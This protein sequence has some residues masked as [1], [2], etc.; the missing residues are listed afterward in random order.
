MERVELH[1]HLLPGVDD[2]PPDLAT[3]LE[4][5]RAAVRDGTR[6]GHLHAACGVRGHRRDSRA[7]A[8][9][10]GRA[11]EAASSSRSAP[12]PSSRGRRAR[13]STPPSSR[14]PPR[15]RP[16]GAG[17]CSKR[18]CRAPARSPTCRTAA[19]ELRDRGYGLL[20]GHP[21]RSPALVGAPGAVERLL[22][23]GDRL[24]V[25]GSS[26]TGY[27][28]AAARAAG[29]E[30]VN[31]GRATAIASDAHRPDERAPSLSAAVAVLRRHGTPDPQAEA[32]VLGRAAGAARA[33]AAGPRP[34]GGLTLSPPPRRGGGAGRAARRSARSRRRPG[35]RGPAVA[36]PMV[37]SAGTSTASGT[38]ATS[39][40]AAASRWR[41][42]AVDVAPP[43]RDVGEQV[44]RDPAQQRRRRHQ[45]RAGRRRARA[46]S[47]ARGRAARCRRPSGSAGTSRSR[48]RS[49]CA[50]GPAAA[51]VQAPAPR[52]GRRRRS[53]ATTAPR[54]STIPSTAA[55]TTP[56][57]TPASAPTPMATIDSP[58]AMMHDQAVALGEVVRARGASPRC[59]T[60]NGP[61][62]SRASA[63]AHSAPWASP[64]AN[65]APH[66]QR[67]RR[68]PC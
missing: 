47:S 24:Q 37:A 15:D 7:G 58:R 43:E 62:M 51:F 5:A 12:A 17:C 55:T 65:D 9:A 33:R 26:L 30:L 21:E 32:L 67:R 38:S 40:I 27:H 10:A 50:P 39:T 18:R 52:R 66:Q 60:S 20:I 19:Q 31:A 42:E 16:A 23:A 14:P 44:E 3:A 54:R 25:N 61:P 11:G 2:G 64:S 36:M 56:A 28:G 34:P 29:L 59:R 41:A 45:R 1:F 35:R 4:L 57:S 68:S 48:A 8:R 49:R 22:A 46:S 13:T 53:R 63:T 6:L